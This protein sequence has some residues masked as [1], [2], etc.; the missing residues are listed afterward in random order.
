MRTT[1]DGATAATSLHFAPLVV[2]PDWTSEIRNICGHGSK[3]GDVRAAAPSLARLSKNTQ[4]HCFKHW[5]AY[6]LI[7]GLATT[8]LNAGLICT[9]CL[10]PFANEKANRVTPKVDCD[11]IAILR[12]DLH[13]ALV[14]RVQLQVESRPRAP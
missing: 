2:Q 10:C 6:Y 1:E 4:L 8:W 11:T 14:L 5:A 3:N 7:L 13:K 12:L 9:T